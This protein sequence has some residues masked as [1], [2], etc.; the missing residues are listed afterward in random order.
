LAL[1]SVLTLAPLLALQSSSFVNLA[2]NPPEKI[3]YLSLH[4]SLP[5]TKKLELAVA[6]AK[7]RITASESRRAVPRQATPTPAKSDSSAPAA[8]HESPQPQPTVAEVPKLP[9]S[10]PIRLDAAT[11]RVANQASKSE[12]NK[13]A[14][15]SGTYIGDDPASES[16]K[17][18]GEIKRIAKEDCLAPNPGGSILSV[19]AIAY[20]AARSKCK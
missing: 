8:I 9:A 16:E 4:S 6:P 2:P 14:E 19:L 18:G 11:I 3:T 5:S 15:V 12:V 20:Q 17:L 1:A 13:M 7:P 10:A